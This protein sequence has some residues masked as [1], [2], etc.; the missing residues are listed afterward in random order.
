MYQNNMLENYLNLIDYEKCTGCEACMNSTRLFFIVLQ[1]NQGIF[2][3]KLHR[4]KDESC[5]D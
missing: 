3:L 4:G 5:R 2:I 1:F